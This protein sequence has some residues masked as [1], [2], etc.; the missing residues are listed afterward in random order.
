LSAI[1]VNDT[2]VTGSTVSA[3]TLTLT[4]ND[5]QD[6][7][8]LS[9]GSNVQFI[10]N[11]NNSITLNATT[12]GGGASVSFPWKFKNPTTS[13][14]PGSG[15]FRLND[16]VASAITEIYVNNFTNNGIDASNLLN[17][18]DVGDVIYIQQND[19]ASRAVLFTVSA[20]T[21]DNTGWFTIPVQYQQGSQIPKK[22]KIC[23]WIFAS[24]G[25][26]DNTVSNV[27]V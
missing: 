8:L 14:D 13:G 20:S 15:Q 25:A 26:E 18:L 22:D 23:G 12:S 27:G 2:F 3:N 7:L 24:T 4:R 17:I 6:V 16:T 9:G 21:V 1:D 19:D 10:D 5:L 11:G